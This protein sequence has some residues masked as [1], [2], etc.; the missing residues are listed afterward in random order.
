MRAIY[1][2]LK[3]FAILSV[4]LLPALAASNANTASTAS[5]GETRLKESSRAEGASGPAGV[6]ALRLQEAFVQTATALRSA[7]VDIAVIYTP[8]DVQPNDYEFFFGVPFD[9]FMQEFMGEESKKEGPDRKK[10]GA[11]K[12]KRKV[13]G[14]GTGVI[15]SPDGY[16]LTNEH[17][18]HGANEITVSL[19]NEKKYRA[20][21]VG[22][23]EHSDI[24]VIRIKPGGKLAHA[25][26]GDSTKVR[27]G[28]WV[29]AMG[30]SFGLE[31]TVTSGIVS[32]VRQSFVIEGKEYRNL[33]Q[34]DAAIN[35]GN[36]GGPLCN[37]R[38]EVI[39]IT[40]AIYAPT[41]VF[42]GVGFAIPVNNAK[43]IM[44]ELIAN[45]K[46]SRGW[47]GIELSAPAEQTASSRG[48]YGAPGVV[49]KKILKGSPAE[50]SSLREGDLI[51]EF[52]GRKVEDA[53][54]FQSLVAH[55]KPDKRVTVKVLRGGRE[56]SLAVV[57]GEMPSKQYLEQMEKEENGVLNRLERGE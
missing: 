7:V 12:E 1:H 17:V 10:D 23:D 31:Y 5:T 42:S 3:R 33:I 40:T 38:G 24:A 30:S 21:V 22:R 14:K 47:L 28:E 43:E 55:T 11:G 37:I 35:R 50:R 45:G 54:V 44:V 26:L 36:S 53:K 15:I 6:E 2:H 4:L 9:E 41:G 48:F 8:E 56:T 46:V 29:I 16:I 27:V 49:V 51:T 19:N 13:E 20:K 34:T 57:T 25:V 52:D 32:A 39:G 18:I